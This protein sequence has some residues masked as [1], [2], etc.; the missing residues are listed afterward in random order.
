MW[1]LILIHRWSLYGCSIT[2]KVYVLGLVKYGLYKQVIFLYR[3]SLDQVSLCC[4]SVMV[5]RRDSNV[6]TIVEQRRVWVQQWLVSVLRL[7]LVFSVF[8]WLSARFYFV[9][10][11]LLFSC[12]VTLHVFWANW[13]TWCFV[14]RV[15][16][17]LSR[18]HM[19]TTAVIGGLH[20]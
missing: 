17:F 13:Q 3:W 18:P 9:A 12:K 7:Q 8:S 5:L 19:G 4:I 6:K 2:F 10:C 20:L 14:A 1:S 16:T 11:L 15:G